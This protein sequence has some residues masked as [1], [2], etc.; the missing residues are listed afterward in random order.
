MNATIECAAGEKRRLTYAMTPGAP[1]VQEEFWLMPTTLAAWQDQ[2]LDAHANLQTEFGLDAPGVHKLGGLGW[3]EAAMVPPFEPK[4]LEDRG[5]LELIQDEAGRGVLVF[6]GKRM[7][8]MPEYETHPVSDEETWEALKPRLDPTHPDR[9]NE[10]D[11]RIAAAKSAEVEGQMICQNLIGGYMYLRSLM[12]PEELLYMF[13]DD[14]DLIHDCM[15]TWLTLSDAVI[16]RH[17]EQITLDEVFLAEDI[18]YNNGPLISP[19]MMREFLFPYY[20]QLLSNIRSRHQDPARRL[21]LQIDTD[22]KA[23]TVIP[24]YQELGMD[25]MSPF[26]VASGCDVVEIGKR[27]PNLV[28]SGGIDKRILSTS[29]EQ[30]D[31]ELER[32]LPVM[33]AR[34]G[35]IPTCDHGVP[36][37]VPLDLYRHYRSRCLEL[38]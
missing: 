37:E 2:G 29:K 15:Q 20:Q 16:A 1:L 30:I 33:K 27:Y 28:L 32:I 21:Y 11:R 26:E 36:E 17:Q 14:P 25:V 8:F 31:R 9:F 7:G 19:D 22:G 38:A 10:L 34:G 18:C 35:Y 6:K 4:V 24:L 12:G 23:E 13:Y 5:D 3:T